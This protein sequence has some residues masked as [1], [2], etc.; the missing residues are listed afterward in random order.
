MGT[1]NV[2]N[3]AGAQHQISIKDGET[4]MEALRDNDMDVEAICGGC[5]SCATCHIFMDADGAAKLPTPSEDELEL[6]TE[7]DHYKEGQSRLSCQVTYKDDM[8]DLALTVAP[9]E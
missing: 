2:T 7:T 1:L 6:L 5:C 9:E 3:R 4:L 8:G